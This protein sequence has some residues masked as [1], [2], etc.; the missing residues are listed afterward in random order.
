MPCKDDRIED[1]SAAFLFWTSTYT[2]RIQCDFAKKSR[3][4]IFGQLARFASMKRAREY[5]QMKKD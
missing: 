5:Y 1:A 2:A 3:S 4:V